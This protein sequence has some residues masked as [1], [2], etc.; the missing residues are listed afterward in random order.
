MP[1]LLIGTRPTRSRAGNLYA[2][3]ERCVSSQAVRHLTGK[4]LD[5]RVIEA[6]ERHAAVRRVRLVGSR[7]AGT[8]T[9]VSDWDFAVETDDFH[10]VARDIGLLVATLDPL[11]EQGERLS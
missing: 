1:E 2:I 5:H 3:R 6:V 10:V 7:A 4:S 11:A 9:S 8:A